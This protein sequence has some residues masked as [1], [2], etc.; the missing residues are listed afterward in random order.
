M[1]IGCWNLV[2]GIRLPRAEWASAMTKQSPTTNN[3][4]LIERS[5]IYV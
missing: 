3:E 1:A 5:E 4:Q 2:V